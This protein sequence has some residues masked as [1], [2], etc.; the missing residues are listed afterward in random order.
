MIEL[1]FA[2][3]TAWHWLA[4]GGFLIIVEAFAPGFMF[5]WLGVAA[6]LV[7]VLLV[8]WPGLPLSGQL[9]AFAVLAVASIFAWRRFQRPPTS[10]RPHLN[11]R[12]AQYVGWHAVL[13]EPIVNGRGRAKL[14]DTSWSVAGPDLAA[15]RIVVITGADGAV[16][17]VAPLA[18]EAD[19]AGAERHERAT[20]PA[21]DEVGRRV[22]SEVSSV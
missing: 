11:R 14:G 6:G 5:A 12:G 15:G 7:G 19:D 18:D 20:G 13:V 22:H 17:E 9:L 4:L 16:L 2:P 10:D 21:A 8:V 3:I 1:V